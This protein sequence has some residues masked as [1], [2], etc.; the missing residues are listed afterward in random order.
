MFASQKLGGTSALPP[1]NGMPAEKNGT[2]YEA[3]QWFG[4]ETGSS[5]PAMTGPRTKLLMVGSPPPA[6]N[7]PSFGVWATV[8][9]L[10]SPSLGR[11]VPAT[12][13]SSLS[14]NSRS[15]HRLDSAISLVRIWLIAFWL[16]L[17]G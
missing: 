11:S 9:V 7:A 8:W 5:T 3:L 13:F 10:S 14:V 12:V 15:S 4:S 2:V 1:R 6:L 17:A 16:P